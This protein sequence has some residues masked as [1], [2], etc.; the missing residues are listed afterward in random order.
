MI[1][2]KMPECQEF[3][4]LIE[5]EKSFLETKANKKYQKQLRKLPDFTFDNATVTSFGNFVFLDKFKEFINF[6][7]DITKYV[8]FKRGDNTVYSD[9]DIMEHMI[10][11]NSVGK[12]RFA[13]YNDLNNDPGL[14]RI[15]GK[16]TN[17]D[18]STCRKL[19]DKTEAENITQLKQ[20][21]KSLLNKKAKLDGPREVWISIDD[22]VSILYGNQEKGTNGY[23]P[24]RK[25]ANSYKIKVAFIQKTDE[26]VNITLNPGNAHSSDRFK[27]FLEETINSLPQNTVLKGILADSGFFS[28]KACKLLEEKNLSYLLKTKIYGSLKKHALSIPEGDWQYVDNNYWVAEKRCRLDNWEHERRFIFIRQEKIRKPENKDQ[29]SLPGMET[30]FTYQIIVTNLEE[31]EL[32][33]EESWHQYNQRAIIE[34]RIEEIKNGF[35]VD[36]NSQKRYLKNYADILI[37]SITYNLINWFK[38]ALLPVDLIKASIR[39]IRRVF[40]NIPANIVKRGGRR[41][42]VRLPKIKGLKEIIETI[43]DRL[44]MFAFRQC[45]SNL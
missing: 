32:S 29:L 17:P 21:M 14:L 41:L 11:S 19:L 39:T 1:P 40:I 3:K 5:E 25:G 20:T 15:K 26:L 8:S 4:S 31:D 45:Y 42:T 35:A 37:K 12:H 30:Y 13:H 23:N 9:Y 27:D 36:K 34:N 43:K 18:E 22:S 6:K 33:P 7:S 28:E 16:D 38:Q 44:Y 10:D 24:K 2:E